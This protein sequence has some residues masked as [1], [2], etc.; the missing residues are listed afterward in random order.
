MEDKLIELTA[1]NRAS[2]GWKFRINR[3][4]IG[5]SGKVVAEKLP[6]SSSY[7]YNFEKG[8]SKNFPNDI[9]MAKL[10]T[11][12]GMAYTEVFLGCVTTEK[13]KSKLGVVSIKDFLKTCREQEFISTKHNDKSSYQQIELEDK[14]MVK[15][16]VTIPITEQILDIIK[17]L[18]F[19]IG[20]LEASMN[21]ITRSAYSIG[22]KKTIPAYSEPEDD[23]F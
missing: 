1:S 19:S 13:K 4:Q 10:A 23:K 20:R 21:Y 12:I 2:I 3:K 16:E 11:T 22:I 17:E 9:T 14:R 15:D 7:L 18:K 6:F 8:R 5:L